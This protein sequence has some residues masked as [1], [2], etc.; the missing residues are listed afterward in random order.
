MHCAQFHCLLGAVTTILQYCLRVLGEIQINDPP[1]LGKFAIKNLGARVRRG[2]ID[3]TQRRGF[4]DA[5]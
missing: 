1:K 4:I 5:R 2:G 3:V